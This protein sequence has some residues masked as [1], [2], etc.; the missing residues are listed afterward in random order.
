[1]RFYFCERKSGKEI[2]VAICDEDILGKKFR[3]HPFILDVKESF[4]KGSLVEEGELESLFKRA[5]ILNLAGE[6]IVTIAMKKGLLKRERIMKIG[7]ALHAQ[8]ARL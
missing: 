6:N 2:I 5:T 8:M 1:M 3:S 7:E 4:Y